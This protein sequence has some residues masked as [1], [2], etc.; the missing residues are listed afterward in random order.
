MFAIPAR[1]AAQTG[2]PAAAVADQATDGLGPVDGDTAFAA[3]LTAANDVPAGSASAAATPVQAPVGP[4]STSP[5]VDA[6]AQS[7]APPITADPITADAGAPLTLSSAPSANSAPTSL[8]TSPAPAAAGLSATGL[9]GDGAAAAFVASASAGESVGAQNLPPALTVS[10]FTASVTAVPVL[11]PAAD[12]SAQSLSL[13][14]SAP[15]PGVVNSDA[16]AAS[17]ASILPSVPAAALQTVSS[18]TVITPPS[19][20]GQA[21][22]G[23]APTEPVATQQ[24]LSPDQTPLNSAPLGSD[25]QSSGLAATA[26]ESPAAPAATAAASTGSPPPAL[27]GNLVQAQ[28]S[29]PAALQSVSSESVSTSSP[30]PPAQALSRAGAVAMSNASSSVV[31][32]PGPVSSASRGSKRATDTPSAVIPQGLTT[33]LQAQLTIAP[34][35]A[36]APSP[37]SPSPANAP[38]VT[39]A[40]SPVASI[41]AAASVVS[42]SSA[43]APLA[44]SSSAPTVSDLGWSVPASSEI[45]ASVPPVFAPAP[46]TPDPVS[47]APTS[48]LTAS[49]LALSSVGQGLAASP[50]PSAGSQVATLSLDLPADSAGLAAGTTVQAVGSS[51]FPSGLAAAEPAPAPA[52]GTAAPTSSVG[53]SQPVSSQSSAIDLT[54]QSDAQPPPLAG[55]GVQAAPVPIPAAQ[56]SFVQPKP[57]A[58]RTPL[59]AGSPAAPPPAPTADSQNA[60]ADATA[61]GATVSPGAAPQISISLT[62]TPTPTLGATL[63]DPLLNTAAPAPGFKTPIQGA[64]KTV[65]AATSATQGVSRYQPGFSFGAPASLAATGGSED[66]GAAPANASSTAS[67]SAHTA[68]SGGDTATGAGIIRPATSQGDGSDTSSLAL[69]GAGVQGP[70]QAQLAATSPV[71]A[72]PASPPTA[73][74]VDNLA[75]QTAAK[76]ADGASQFQITLTPEG[77]GQVSV[78]VQV[79]AEGRVSAAFAFEKSDTAD[80]L[81][82]RSADLQKALEQAGFSVAPDGLS[83]SVA[84]RAAHEATPTGGQASGQFA[85]TSGQGSG[86]SGAGGQNSNNQGNPAAGPRVRRRAAPSP[87]PPRPRLLQICPSAPPTPPAPTPGWISAS[88]TDP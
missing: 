71:A 40:A 3:L 85:Q 44:A 57:E 75:T 14:P 8:A 46:D 81:S 88:R 39:A 26:I 62:P 1:I 18:E 43:P 32:V 72:S 56:P 78:A 10:T 37:T 36:A 61:P 24:A 17:D 82:S 29:I 79:G 25:R 63:A 31:G 27:G 51:P 53:E 87:P 74:T 60:L 50:S 42:A 21:N 4:V 64:S 41:A 80:A 15:G 84:P 20:I 83:F 69:L 13:P 35:P 11:S 68:A 5:A 45:S 33:A 48:N 70:A 47:S 22:L 65:A 30:G 12:A 28:L 23:P 19:E 38:P 49:D 52:A 77:L 34:Q 76:A 66:T 2:A 58:G 73:E 59:T 55:S 9:W 6:T 86:G 54:P 7:A 16:A 67:P